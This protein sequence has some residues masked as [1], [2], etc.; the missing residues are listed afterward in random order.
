MISSAFM[1]CF[2]FR[3]QFALL[4]GGAFHVASNVPQSGR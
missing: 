3:V 2:S 4:S 1:F